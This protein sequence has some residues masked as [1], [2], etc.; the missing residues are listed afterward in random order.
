MNPRPRRR[1]LAG[2]HKVQHHTT[3]TYF[4]IRYYGDHTTSSISRMRMIYDIHSFRIVWYSEG[5]ETTA[6]DGEKSEQRRRRSEEGVRRQHPI[7]ITQ[8][9]YREQRFCL[10]PFIRQQQK[11]DIILTASSC[12]TGFHALLSHYSSSWRCC[13]PVPLE[14][15]LSTAFN[16]P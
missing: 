5:H 11:F 16:L 3:Q 2:C 15:H 10:S 1:L 6:P 9:R 12:C 7:I 13:V 14:C 4:H 8:L